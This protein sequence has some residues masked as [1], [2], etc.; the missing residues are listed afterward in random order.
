MDEL[1]VY[2]A[3]VVDWPKLPLVYEA[4]GYT[5]AAAGMRERDSWEV[6]EFLRGDRLIYLAEADGTT[7]GTVA[8]VFRGKDAGLAD[9]V[10]S[11]HI[12]R[13]HVVQAYRRRGV[14]AALLAAGEA[15]ARRRGFRRLTIEVEDNN[16]PA[17]ALYEKLG[18]RYTGRGHAPDEL[19]MAKELA[20]A[21]A[22]QW[23]T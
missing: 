14:A 4:A 12:N 7:V 20:V 21:G 18:Y 2:I 3:G 17:R 16:P 23:Q 19:A 9:G 6:E 11:A 10:T 22:K 1:T 13:L 5:R 15:E 8:L